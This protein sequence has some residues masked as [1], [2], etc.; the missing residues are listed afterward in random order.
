M[1]MKIKDIATLIESVA[2]LQL[3][4]SYDN[5]GLQVGDP[6]QEVTGVLTT[7][8]VTEESV[9]RAIQS[10]ANLIVSH[11]PLLFHGVKQINPRRDYISRVLIEA[12]R[13]DIAVY[14]AH[15]NLDNAP[16]G[17]NRRMAD[18]LGLQ[19]VRPLAPLTKSQTSGLSADFANE[20]G[21][22]MIGRLPK[23]L[24]V[25]DFIQL[26]KERFSIPAVMAN[27]EDV[28]PSRMVHAVALCG[29]AGDDFIPDAVRAGADAFLTGEVSYHL[30]FGHPELLI[31]CGGHF[32]TEQYTC[33]LLKEL[34]Q[35]KYPDLAVTIAPKS[36]PVMC[37]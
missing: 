34:I 27:S 29:G 15:T 32:E 26:V 7:L 11:H 23:P 14:S 37:F 36:S 1:L 16:Q 22:G 21:S 19:D 10:G 24:H 8:D 28:D 9:Q 18:V 5:A 17:V 20:C 25:R 31:L 4:E 3:Q 33:Q 35:A 2:P 30:Y 6:E 13:Q 12:I